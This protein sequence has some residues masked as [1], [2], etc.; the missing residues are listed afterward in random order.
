M[1]PESF[2]TTDDKAGW[3][4]IVAENSR[5]MEDEEFTVLV[6]LESKFLQLSI[7]C[8]ELAYHLCPEMK[9]VF[10]YNGD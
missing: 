3:P 7:S 1:A 6:S 9:A 2:G 5:F 10:P 4:T 8:Q